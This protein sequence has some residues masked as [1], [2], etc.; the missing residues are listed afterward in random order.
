MFP[1]IE[2]V[3]LTGNELVFLYPESFRRYLQLQVLYL[4]ESHLTFIGN[5]EFYR[6]QHLE[7]IVLTHNQK[8]YRGFN[9]S[10][11]IFK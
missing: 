5:N 10:P 7:T 6:L 8:K 11:T 3:I 4:D 9:Y 2:T 1:D